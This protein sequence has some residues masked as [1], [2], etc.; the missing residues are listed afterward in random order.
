M[1]KVKTK[2][3]TGFL[4]ELLSNIDEK[5]LA[6]TRKRMM[7][8]VKIEKAIK[9]CGYN[10]EQ[11]AHL[12]KKS[13]TV[14]SEWLSGDRNFT[15]DTLVEIEEALGIRL[16]DVSVMTVVSANSEMTKNVT[17]RTSKKN[18]SGKLEFSAYV[19]EYNNGM[20]SA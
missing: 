12:M 11:F 15:I 14:I 1:I 2:E 7:L 13:P 5:E 19:S 16:I 20:K 18:F 9:R 8:A 3:A 6:K 4:A 17:K 10:Q